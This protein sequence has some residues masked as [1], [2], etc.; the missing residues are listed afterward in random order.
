MGGVELHFS[1][2]GLRIH[3]PHSLPR[4]ARCIIRFMGL[5]AGQGTAL[6]ARLK[7]LAPVHR[8]RI[9]C[10]RIHAG[11]TPIFHGCARIC[12]GRAAVA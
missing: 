11:C 8:A 12:D 1:P 7:G 2:D 4:K 9:R 6:A 5:G 10:A 3:G